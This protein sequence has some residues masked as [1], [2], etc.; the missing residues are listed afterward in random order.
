VEAP[1]PAGPPE[2]GFLRSPSTR[3][4]RWSLLLLAVAVVLFAVA[5]IAV[6]TG[7]EGGET[8]F[9]NLW[10]SVP[11]LGAGAT[12]LTAGGFAGFAIIR[13]RE[14]SLPVAGVMAFGL[15]VFLFLVGEISSPH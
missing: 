5:N 10:I 1:G 15:L 9:D 14:R 3:P 11:M 2:H 12:V 6:A 4:G 13:R 7:Q 8:V